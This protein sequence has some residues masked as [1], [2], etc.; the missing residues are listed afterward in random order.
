[1]LFG[2]CPCRCLSLSPPQRSMRSYPRSLRD[3]GRARSWNLAWSSENYFMPLF[4]KSASLQ[5]RESLGTSNWRS[6][7]RSIIVL[8]LSLAKRGARL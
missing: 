3:P 7:Y 2:A 4:S 6:G 8:T 1:M 5:P